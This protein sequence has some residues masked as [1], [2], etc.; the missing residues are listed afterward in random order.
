[1]KNYHKY[2]KLIKRDNLKNFL[3]NIGH[4]AK[5]I[6]LDNINSIISKSGH[7][8]KIIFIGLLNFFASP[9]FYAWIILPI[10]FTTILYILDHLSTTKDKLKSIFFF[11]LGHFLGQLYWIVMPLTFDPMHYFVIPLAIVFIPLLITACFIVFYLIFFH[12]SKKFNIAK[13]GVSLLLSF[14]IC[15]TLGEFLRGTIVFGGFPWMLPC[16]FIP[17]EFAMQVV[18]FKYI[19]LFILSFAVIL[20]VTLPYFLVSKKKTKYDKHVFCI[21]SGLWLINVAFGTYILIKTE[22]SKKD[23][24]NI[25]VIGT[26]INNQAYSTLDS[27]SAIDLIK[28]NVGEVS[29]VSGLKKRAIVIFP[30][31]SVHMTLQSGNAPAKYISSVLPNEDPSILVTGS[32]TVDESDEYKIFNT[33]HFL[34]HGG[35]VIG[36]Y[37][38]QKLVPFGEYIPLRKYIPNFIKA[39]GESVDFGT[40]KNIDEFVAYKDLPALFPVIC[41]ESIFSDFIRDRIERNAHLTKETDR[42][43]VNVTNDIWMR[44]S[45]GPYQHLAMSKLTAIRARTSMIRVSNNGISAFIDK[46]G[47]IMTRTPLNKESI[48]AFEM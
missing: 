24:K 5:S 16:H 14:S 3:L 15:W 10:T 42:V 31:S 41:Y 2:T 11:I 21:I 4:A 46:T 45:N 34:I 12:I 27:Q 20:L 7:K 35:H 29:W 26:Q 22:F 13:S 40:S 9:P 28:K 30:E 6:Y 37:K 33:I 1:M 38:K 48:L 39:I 23:D 8:Y 32:V 25:L 36:M 19:N 43:I 17:Y 18:M 44:F 47:K